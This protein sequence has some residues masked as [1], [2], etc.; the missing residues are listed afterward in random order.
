MSIDL[1]KHQDNCRNLKAKI[2]K[3][4]ERINN[5]NQRNREQKDEIENEINRCNKTN[6]QAFNDL[7]E[8]KNETNE[9]LNKKRETER[10]IEEE[11][12]TFRE[13]ENDFMKKITELN[14][15]IAE[16]KNLKMN[17]EEDKSDEI[18]FK[19]MKSLVRKT[20][21]EREEKRSNVDTALSSV[22][23]CEKQIEILLDTI[24][25]KFQENCKLM[26]K[27][28]DI[29][30]EII[31]KS[32]DKNS[33]LETFNE[34]MTK[35]LED[36]CNIMINKLDQETVQE[37]IKSEEFHKDILAIEQETNKN[38]NLYIKE[39]NEKDELKNG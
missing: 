16:R 33:T 36:H 32:E 27:N 14:K 23:K 8:T 20:T 2:D 6:K 35:M 39:C 15:L 37:K 22:Q 18:S 5:E 10:R 38:R 30:N 1:A 4:N 17:L 3:T 31:E 34:K 9:I 28:Q 19:A 11:N 7:L 25:E 21:S 24:K 13:L 29:Q 26:R 12:K